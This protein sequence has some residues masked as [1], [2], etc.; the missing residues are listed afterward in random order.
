[1]CA[2]ALAQQQSGR[3]VVIYGLESECELAG[4]LSDRNKGLVDEL[5]PFYPLLALVAEQKLYNVAVRMCLYGV[6]GTQSGLPSNKLA[7]IVSTHAFKQ[8]TKCT[9]RRSASRANGNPHASA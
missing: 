4:S 9:C 2:L 6:V 5:H 1:M 7:R 3:Q 8:E